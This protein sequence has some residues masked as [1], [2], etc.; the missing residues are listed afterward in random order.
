MLTMK[1][2][3]VRNNI[4]ITRDSNGLTFAVG[5]YLSSNFL[6]HLP[7]ATF[8]IV[9]VATSEQYLYSTIQSYTWFQ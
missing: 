9:L 7:V 5:H 6:K 2:R 3:V 4:R 8:V 1:Y